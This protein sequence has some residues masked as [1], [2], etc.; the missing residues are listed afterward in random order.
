MLMFYF[1]NSKKK[2]R[3]LSVLSRTSFLDSEGNPFAFILIAAEQL[4]LFQ[5]NWH[6]FWLEIK[7]SMRVSFYDNYLYE[8][9]WLTFSSDSDCPWN[10]IIFR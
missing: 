8:F 5:I 3:Q 10:I 9:T 6:I 4:P 1:Q 7:V 2:K